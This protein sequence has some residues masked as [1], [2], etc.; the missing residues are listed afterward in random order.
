MVNTIALTTD[1]IPLVA[2]W[3]GWV[4]IVIALV[5]SLFLMHT[6]V[7]YSFN[8]VGA[9]TLGIHGLVMFITIST[10]LTLMASL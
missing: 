8:G 6:W 3:V 2:Y 7:R 1:L 5:Y 9:L 4:A 10:L